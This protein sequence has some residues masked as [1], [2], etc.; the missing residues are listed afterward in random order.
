MESRPP[1]S[2]I[3]EV[4]LH[5]EEGGGHPQ[6][7]WGEGPCSPASRR[8]CSVPRRAWPAPQGLPR[9][10]RP[11]GSP[12]LWAAGP[13]GQSASFCVEK[14]AVHSA[15]GVSRCPSS[16]PPAAHCTQLAQGQAASEPGHVSRSWDTR[17]LHQHQPSRPPAWSPHAGPAKQDM[18]F[19][20]CPGVAWVVEEAT[21][22]PAPGEMGHAVPGH[23]PPQSTWGGAAPA[24]KLQAWGKRTRLRGQASGRKMQGWRHLPEDSVCAGYTKFTAIQN[25]SKTQTQRFPKA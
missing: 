11:L 7:G 1:C 10:R 25:K 18:T 14:E 23:S 13:R 20:P 17:P 19:L 15:G 3:T 24:P 9:S 5:Q 8:P 22:Q 2:G 16:G 21:W 12:T 4:V 6:A